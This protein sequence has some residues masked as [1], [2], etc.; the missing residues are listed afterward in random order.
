MLVFGNLVNILL[1]FLYDSLTDR[2]DPVSGMFWS[3]QC[4]YS[5][6]FFL[7][8]VSGWWELLQLNKTFW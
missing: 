7:S 8:C 6:C 3:T 1:C 2:V 5:T 4:F